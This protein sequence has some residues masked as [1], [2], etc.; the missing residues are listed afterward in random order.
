MKAT[1]QS[2]DVTVSFEVPASEF[3]MDRQISMPWHRMSYDWFTEEAFVGELEIAVG[4]V[5]FRPENDGSQSNYLAYLLH[6]AA[7]AEPE[8]RHRAQWDHFDDSVELFLTFG[9]HNG[10][11]S[12]E[13]GDVSARAS[14]KDLLA[15]V[16]AC[17]QQVWRFIAD[18]S[19]GVLRNKAVMADELD[20]RQGL[21]ASGVVVNGPRTP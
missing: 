14:R 3:A 9:T 17:Y 7:R 12:L 18:K 8:Q 2:G 10:R 4:G 19:P 20:W 1:G 16:T 13:Q 21:R 5:L 15:A 11:V 6:L